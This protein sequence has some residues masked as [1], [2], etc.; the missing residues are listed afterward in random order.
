MKDGDEKTIIAQITE[1]S[2]KSGNK[3][4]KD[5]TRYVFKFANGLTMSTFD[6]RLKDFKSGDTVEVMFKKSG[7]YNNILDM[8][9]AESSQIVTADKIKS[10]PDQK[11]WIEKDRRIIRQNCNQRAIE[12]AELMFKVDPE[13]FKEILKQSNGLLSI[14]D[15]YA[16][17]FE[18]K[19]WDEEVR[20]IESEKITEIEEVA[21]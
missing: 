16:K 13:G 15:S 11:V 8:R 18:N 6:N 21:M 19:V 1:N 9:K 7:Q 14:I 12:T 20:K 5:W 2:Q 17:H 4:G 10:E 3:D